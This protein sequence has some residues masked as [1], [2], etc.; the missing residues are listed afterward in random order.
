MSTVVPKVTVAVEIFSIDQSLE[1]FKFHPIEIYAGEVVICKRA[2]RDW[3]HAVTRAT[4]SIE[5][6]NVLLD[7]YLFGKQQ[8]ML[9]SIGFSPPLL[10][11][12]EKSGGS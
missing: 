3:A 2:M 11:V 10:I 9:F 4:A 7:F 12:R 8:T 6:L 5:G 1:E